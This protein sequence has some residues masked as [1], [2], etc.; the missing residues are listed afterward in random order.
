[1][2]DADRLQGYLDGDLTATEREA[3]EEEVARNPDLRERLALHRRLEIALGDSKE[4][5]VE[6]DLAA[7]M[8]EL[9]HNL[10]DD[11]APPR[12]GRSSGY[13]AIAASLAILL[14]GAWFFFLRGCSAP[15]ELYAQHYTAYDG[16]TELRSENGIPKSLLSSAFDTYNEGNY[17]EALQRFAQIL[18]LAPGNP[19]A[20]FYQGIC[21]METGAFAPAGESF[22]RV[23]A[24]GQNLYLSQAS[25]YLAM[26]CLKVNDLECAKAQLSEL[27]G[28]TGRY[29]DAA[30][31]ILEEL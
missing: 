17:R 30:A 27:A 19:R 5:K 2:E 21:Q 23:L 26:T 22:R 16:S 3:F 11:Q 7:I 15:E 12:R 24:D 6:A 18:K 31:E 13:F 10:Q 4:E 29:R 9:P 25:W 1:M 28:A 8:A 20:L 14:V